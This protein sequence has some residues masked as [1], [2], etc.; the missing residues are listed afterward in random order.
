MAQNKTQSTRPGGLRARELEETTRPADTLRNRRRCSIRG[1]LPWRLF[2]GAAGTARTPRARRAA[3]TAR[4]ERRRGTARPSRP[5]G[6]S[7]TT[8]APRPARSDGIVGTGGTARPP[9]IK[10]PACA[11]PR[12]VRPGKPMRTRLQ[13]RRKACLRYLPG[14]RHQ[15]QTK[16]RGRDSHL[17][18]HAGTGARAVHAAVSARRARAI[19]KFGRASDGRPVPTFPGCAARTLFVVRFTRAR[20]GAERRRR[21]ESWPRCGSAQFA[22]ASE[23]RRWLRQH[24]DRNNTGMGESPLFRYTNAC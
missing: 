10:R 4:R 7:R 8:R 19:P 6:S 21:G 14:R 20:G 12:N 13:P 17:Q 23:P 2:R 3:G 22:A 11:Q 18:Q 1:P 16:H 15:P 5:A 24:G 9:W